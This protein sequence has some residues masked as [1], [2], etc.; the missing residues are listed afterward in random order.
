MP[1]PDI[2]LSL[3][4]WLCLYMPAL[5]E[6]PIKQG[7]ETV[8]DVF[9][10]PVRPPAAGTRIAWDRRTMKRVS[11][12]RFRNSGYARMIQLQ[13]KSLLCVYE[14]DG[15]VMATKSRDIGET[16]DEP[17]AVAWKQ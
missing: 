14:A 6:P 11:H 7:A 10:L 16:W 8:A 5:P 17:V 4:T 3:L 13:D 2:M 9:L 12:E 1:K 15:S